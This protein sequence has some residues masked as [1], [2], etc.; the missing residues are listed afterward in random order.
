MENVSKVL[1]GIL[2]LSK[3]GEKHEVIIRGKTIKI[4][5]QKGKDVDG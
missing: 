2:P 3:I 5:T 4:K 1:W